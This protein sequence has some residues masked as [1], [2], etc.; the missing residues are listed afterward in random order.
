[1]DRIQIR[2]FTLGRY[3]ELT[4]YNPNIIICPYT[5]PFGIYKGFICGKIAEV[6]YIHPNG[7][8]NF[9]CRECI[10]SY[11]NNITNGQNNI[12]IYMKWFE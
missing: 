7:S 12:G 6:M 1:M 9:M 5:P 2:W 10:I 8:F 3:L 11:T 4:K